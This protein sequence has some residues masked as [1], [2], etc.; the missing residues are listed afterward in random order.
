MKAN[1]PKGADL[2]SEIRRQG[3]KPQ[4]PVYIFLDADRPRPKIYRDL[5]LDI[6]ICIRP[7]E[8]IEAF[9]YGLLSGLTVAV[10]AHELN[11][12]LR[13]LLICI[14][15]AQPLSIGGVV[16]SENLIYSWAPSMGWDYAHV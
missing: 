4:S 7:N 6:E 12:R 1:L 14:K 16:L 11:D 5:P 2:L 3:F 9:D 15:Q 13:L 10:V 8:L